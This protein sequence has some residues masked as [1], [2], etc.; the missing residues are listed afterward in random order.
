MTHFDEWSDLSLDQRADLRRRIFV[1]LERS[2]DGLTAASLGYALERSGYEASA[3]T[4]GKAIGALSFAGAI[5]S[6][7]TMSFGDNLVVWRAKS[8]VTR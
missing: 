4:I 6:T 2:E 1:E 5:S 3:E 8:R 7:T